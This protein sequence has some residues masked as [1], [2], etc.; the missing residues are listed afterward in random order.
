MERPK[1]RQ[2]L[3]CNFRAPNEEW[4][5]VWLE[6]KEKTKAGGLDICFVVLNL[7]R[8]WLKAQKDAESIYTVS[9]MRQI[10]FLTQTNNFNYN[11]AKPRPERFRANC[12]KEYPK[13]TICS[14]AFGAYVLVTAKAIDREFCFRDFPELNHDYFRKIILQLKR[15]GKLLAMKPRALPGFYIL[16]EWK[17]RYPTMAGEQ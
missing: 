1:A 8:A 7:C 3:H 15:E 9:G 14:K 16:P 6:L 5:E 12:S 11:V 10:V 2:N 13:C 17:D 4:F